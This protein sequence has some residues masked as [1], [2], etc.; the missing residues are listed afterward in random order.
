MKFRFWSSYTSR[1]GKHYG[2]GVAAHEAVHTRGW[3]SGIKVYPRSED[4][5]TDTLDAFYV[6]ATHGSNG[7]GSDMPLGKLVT[8]PKTGEPKWV[9]EPGARR[10]KSWDKLMQPERKAG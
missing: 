5:G 1:N 7:Q 4:T 10:M 6:V 9:P 3:R 8:D 2:A